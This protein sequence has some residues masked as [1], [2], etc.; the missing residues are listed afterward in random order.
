M[1]GVGGGSALDDHLEDFEV[2]LLFGRDMDVGLSRE[3]LGVGEH[4][5]NREGLALVDEAKLLGGLLVVVEL[6]PVGWRRP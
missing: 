4:N 2:R 6:E 5:R 1:Q 3:L